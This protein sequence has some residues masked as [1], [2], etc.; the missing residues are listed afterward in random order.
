MLLLVPCNFLA[1]G[2]SPLGYLRPD[3]SHHPTTTCQKLL[4]FITFYHFL[5]L[6]ERSQECYRRQK[7]YEFE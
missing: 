2:V 3:I 6:S 5:S 1:Q 7:L 4:L